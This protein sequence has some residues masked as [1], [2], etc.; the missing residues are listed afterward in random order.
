MIISGKFYQKTVDKSHLT[1][2]LFT[3]EL[4]LDLTAQL[5]PYNK[6]SSIPNFLPE[7]LNLDGR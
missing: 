5:F 1:M 2:D 4:V 3:I 7:E 6:L